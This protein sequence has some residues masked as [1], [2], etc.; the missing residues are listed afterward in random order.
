MVS[1]AGHKEVAVALLMADAAPDAYSQQ[2]ATQLF[3]HGGIVQKDSESRSVQPGLAEVNIQP[4]C[5]DGG[6]IGEW[7]PWYW[8]ALRPA[9]CA[10][11]RGRCCTERRGVDPWAYGPRWRRAWHVDASFFWQTRRGRAPPLHAQRK[12][13]QGMTAH[14]QPPPPTGP[15]TTRSALQWGGWRKGAGRAEVR[16]EVRGERLSRTDMG[17][18]TCEV[19]LVATPCSR[20][21]FLMS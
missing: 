7:R 21:F 13:G 9:R 18:H 17:L 15:P 14:P 20:S 16:A 5:P 8:C 11:L 10:A 4:L 19:Q 1:R 6:T 12:H 2:W 3:V